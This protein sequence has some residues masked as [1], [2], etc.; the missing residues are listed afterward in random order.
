MDRHEG[1]ASMLPVNYFWAVLSK[2]FDFVCSEYGMT[3]EI[4]HLFYKTTEYFDYF[5]EIII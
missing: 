5:I 1:H 4:E 2:V 3:S